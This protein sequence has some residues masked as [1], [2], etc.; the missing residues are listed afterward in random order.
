MSEALPAPGSAAH[1]YLDLVALAGK[2]RDFAGA[3]TEEVMA[4]LGDLSGLVTTTQ[5]SDGALEVNVGEVV[6]P[7]SFL[8]T[9]LVH[10]LAHF[11]DVGVDDVIE[12]VRQQLTDAS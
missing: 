6:G 12:R 1:L 4:V 2:N 9:V 8:I 7:A 3:D 11:H 10:T 5:R